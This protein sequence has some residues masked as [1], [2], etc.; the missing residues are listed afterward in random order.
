MSGRRLNASSS[1]WSQ[2]GGRVD[3]VVVE[4]DQVR[5]R[6]QPERARVRVLADVL[7]ADHDADARIVERAQVLGRC[8]RARRCPRSRSRVSRRRCGGGRSRRTSAAGGRGCA[9]ARRP[10]SRPRAR[11]RRPP[12]ASS[13]TVISIARIVGGASPAGD[14]RQARIAGCAPSRTASS[15]LA[16]RSWSP[17]TAR[18][19]R[20]VMGSAPS[21][22]ADLLLV[23]SSGGHLLQLVALRESW[24]PLHPRLGDVRQ[25]RRPLAARGRAGRLRARADEPEH[26]E[27]ASQPARRAGAS[28]ATSRPKVIADDRGGRRR[29]VRVGRQA[30]RRQ[31]RLRREPRADRGPVAQLPADRAGRRAAAT[32]SGRSSRDVARRVAVRRQRLL[33]GRM[34]FVTVG[35]NEARFD[36]LLEA[37]ARARDRRGARR[38]STAT[39]RRSLAPAR[40]SSTSCRSRRWSRRSGGH[41]RSSPMP[42]SARSWS[43]WRTASG[44]SSSR[45]GRRS[46][47]RSTTTS[48]SSAAASRRPGS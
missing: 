32:C 5:R 12:Q 3:D 22:R 41:A 6:R 15:A 47:R 29:A 18:G 30:A 27:P 21:D 17:G 11:E 24:E 45:A 39:R 10:R 20:V 13:G 33:G 14:G 36:R 26:Q 9:S 48:S 35:T 34:I 43:R 25:E 28:S 19:Y 31:G 4:L 7:L 1:I 40:R 8:R 23:C 16:V 44:R 2:P 38:S 42:A 37:V 46:A